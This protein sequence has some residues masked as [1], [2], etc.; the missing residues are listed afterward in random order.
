MKANL[1]ITLERCDVVSNVELDPG[2]SIVVV[3]ET[4]EEVLN[5]KHLVDYKQHRAQFL[6]WLLQFGKKPSNAFGYADYTVYS[7]AYRT[8]KFDQWVW[9]E[10]GS[11]KYPSSM[12]GAT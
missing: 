10:I 6:S 12:N 5:K 2:R 4:H 8:A 1:P 7:E 11:C 3:R 9:E